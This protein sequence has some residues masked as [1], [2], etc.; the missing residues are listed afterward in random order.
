M[1]TT[2]EP[3]KKEL[4]STY[5]VQDRSNQNELTRVMLQDQLLTAG[6]GGVL[7]EQQNAKQW[8]HILDIGCGTGYWLVEAAK[9]YPNLTTLVGIDISSK[10]VDYARTRAREHQVDERVQ[11]H[12]M[13][14]LRTLEFP[15]G[16]FD[17]VN[18]RFGSSYL[19]TWDWLNML[20]EFRRVLKH[21]G[22]ARLTE[23]DMVESNS[24]GLDA[25]QEILIRAF[26][27]AGNTLA[28]QL[29]GITPGLAN[30]LQQSGFK[31]VQTKRYI[32]HY[33]AGTSEWQLLFEDLRHSFRNLLPFFNKWTHVPDNYQNIYQ[34]ALHEM[35]QP[36]FTANWPLLTAWGSKS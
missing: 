25:L 5:F 19:R 15:N 13:D 21:Q 24:P 29:D 9:T 2:P 34:Q 20:N 33:Q 8:T 1:S 30:F 36:D 35:Q 28:P 27:R 17:F 4:S 22:I 10:M 7:S 14:A 32:L 6:M 31:N 16:S 12:V 23:P 3:H 18:L 11:F 26:Y